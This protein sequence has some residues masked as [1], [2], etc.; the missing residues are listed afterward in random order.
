MLA[1]HLYELPTPL[2][3]LRPDVPPDLESVVLRCLAKVPAER[4]ASA[5]DLDAGLAGCQ[6]AGT[7]TARDAADWWRCHGAANG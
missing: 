3:R 5:N 7:W 6:A 4:Y 2:T 1:A